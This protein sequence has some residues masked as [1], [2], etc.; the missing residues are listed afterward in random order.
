MALVQGNKILY[1]QTWDSEASHLRTHWLINSVSNWWEA[2]GVKGELR[3]TWWCLLC[4]QQQSGCVSVSTLWKGREG[5]EANCGERRIEKLLFWE[6]SAKQDLLLS[7]FAWW[8]LDHSAKH[9]DPH[10]EMDLKLEPET[11]LWSKDKLYPWVAQ[12]ER[13]PLPENQSKREKND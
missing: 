7:S 4:S 1:W 10:S 2:K 3:N 5:N 6:D 9:R 13:N 11:L 12:K 8:A